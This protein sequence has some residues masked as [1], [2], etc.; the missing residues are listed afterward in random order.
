MKLHK[1]IYLLLIVLFFTFSCTLERGTIKPKKNL[2][3]GTPIYY[4][5]IA[6]KYYNSKEYEKA[7]FQYKKIINAFSDQ[8]GKYDKELAWAEYEI[9]FCYM[10]LKDPKNAS[11]HFKQVLENYNENPA[12]ILSKI[13]LKEIESL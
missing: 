4:D 1:I 8:K 7:I 2:V 6:R 5:F 13:K 11:L 9:G 10:K 12:R 3:K